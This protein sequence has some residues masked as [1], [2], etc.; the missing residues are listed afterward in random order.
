MFI[1]FSSLKAANHVNVT[2]WQIISVTRTRLLKSD[3]IIKKTFLLI[4]LSN[5]FNTKR[6]AWCQDEKKAKDAEAKRKRLEEAEKKR[7]AMLDAMKGE[8]DTTAKPNFVVTKRGGGGVGT[9]SRAGKILNCSL[10]LLGI[11]LLML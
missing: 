7:Q 9:V 4:R 10:Y 1:G 3:F 11:F 5:P 6:R 2:L 8:K